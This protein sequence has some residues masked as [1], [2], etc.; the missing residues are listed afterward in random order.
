MRSPDLAKQPLDAAAV[1]FVGG[2]VDPSIFD[3]RLAPPD[4]PPQD[5]RR[6]P[7]PPR[8]HEF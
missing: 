5:E 8:D 1:I 6:E 7:P 3:L 4:A 2:P